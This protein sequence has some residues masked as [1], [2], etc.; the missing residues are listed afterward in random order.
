MSNTAIDSI[1]HSSFKRNSVSQTFLSSYNGTNSEMVARGLEA[2]GECALAITSLQESGMEHPLAQSATDLTDDIDSIHFVSME[3]FIHGET[4]WSEIMIMQHE[5]VTNASVTASSHEIEE[6]VE[7]KIEL[8]KTGYQTKDICDDK[9]TNDMHKTLLDVFGATGD[10]IAGLVSEQQRLQ[11]SLDGLATFGDAVTNC[12]QILSDTHEVGA[13]RGT[14]EQCDQ[15]A[16]AARLVGFVK[17]DDFWGE[18]VS[19]HEKVRAAS[20]IVRGIARSAAQRVFSYSYS[21]R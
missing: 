18:V 4:F 19:M 11:A 14:Y 16:A 9:E 13:V 5:T 8:L 17:S 15:S 10:A 7:Q 20:A 6:D 3:K 12:E 21:Y 1:F 2:F